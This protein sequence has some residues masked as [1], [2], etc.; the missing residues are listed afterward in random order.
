[1]RDKKR[2][3]SVTALS[4]EGSE[5]EMKVL[6]KSNHFHGGALDDFGSGLIQRSFAPH[7]GQK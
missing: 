7:S 6:V 3:P 1:M 2:S 5:G 4:E